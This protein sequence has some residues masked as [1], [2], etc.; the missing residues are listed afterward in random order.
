MLWRALKHI[1]QG[2][3]IDVGTADPDEYSVTRAFSDHGW[4]GINIEA[5][6]PYVARIAGAR[7]RDVTLGVAAG[8][9]AGS[10][11]FFEVVGTG[12]ST[13]DRV[14]AEQ[15]RVA[16]YEIRE[17]EVP[18]RILASICADYAPA[19]IHFLKIDVE[20]TER[21]VLARAVWTSHRPWIVLL[22]ATKPNPQEQNHL[23]WE[24]LLL[25]A[26]N[27]LVWFDGLNRFYIAAEFWDE[28]APASAAPPNLFDDFVRATGA[29]HLN[30]IV[31]AETRAG[32]AEERAGQAAA[33]AAQADTRGSSSE[34]ILHGQTRTRHSRGREWPCES[35]RRASAGVVRQ[36][37]PF[38]LAYQAARL[39]K[40]SW[41]VVTIKGWSP[42]FSGEL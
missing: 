19:D 13:M 20:G 11:P 27:R 3:W 24:P 12:M 26:N 31:G 9:S 17:H 29:E 16:G 22:E 5:N 37:R 41:F 34:E 35:E 7:P 38:I 2:F 21:D 28:L 1:P 40:F 32:Q 10:V 18:S 15:H 4:C 30:R 6:P 39:A 36:D 23:K 25:A 8:A 14:I 42:P 33:H